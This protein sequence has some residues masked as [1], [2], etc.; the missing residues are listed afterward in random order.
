MSSKKD[1]AIS[2]KGQH[3]YIGLDIH[4]K[5]WAVNIRNNGIRLKAFSM[6]P[7]PEKLKRFLE[8]NYPE[9]TYHVVYE[10]GFCGFWICRILREMGIDCI[11]V[12]PADILTGHKE[13]DR[14]TDQVDANKLARELE[15]GS[16]K[17][18]Y[19]PD[20]ADQHLRS[21]CRLYRTALQD[22]TRVKNRIKGRL[23]FNGVELPRH[24]SQWSGKFI[25]YLKSLP[26]DDGPAKECL[27]I[28]I[29]ELEQRRQTTIHI[30]KK[31][32]EYVRDHREPSVFQN[33]LTVPG[34]GLKTA[35]VLYT[36]IIDM[37][38]F[39]TLD[40]LKSFVGLVPSTDSSGENDWVRGL[41]YRKNKHLK[42]VLIEA[43]WVAIR[44]D[45]V[46]LHKYNKLIVR[47]K[48]QNAIIKIAVKLLDR[49]RYVWNNNCP[50]V[51][52]VIQ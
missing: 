35:F 19:I 11:V 38:R 9:G 42:H 24:T 43:A 46:L 22:T 16:L 37:K 14:K 44:Q 51:Q 48:A 30:L 28:S 27:M 33:L 52:G 39:R 49:I 41:T 36:E 17:C 25:A 18:I 40:H 26:L 3:F 13:K 45:P 23:Y 10:V 8:E 6:D 2:F 20:E 21:L 15:K 32:R 4:K 1:N 47:M 31:L 29:D 50:Y 34:V 12:N 5:N 7:Y